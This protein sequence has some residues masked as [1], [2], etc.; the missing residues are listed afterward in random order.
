MLVM[1]DGDEGDARVPNNLLI[2]LDELPSWHDDGYIIP[3][4][5]V[6]AVRNEYFAGD[7]TKAASDHL[8]AIR[9]SPRVLQFEVFHLRV[10]DDGKMEKVER[11]R[12]V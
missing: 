6:K 10:R 8:G 7:G 3:L 2:G 1:D 11:G 9:E 5:F 4:E 12:C